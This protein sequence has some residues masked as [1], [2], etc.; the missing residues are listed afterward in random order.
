M[1]ERSKVECGRRIWDQGLLGCL[2]ELH[3]RY[4]ELEMYADD[5]LHFPKKSSE[6][7]NL[8]VPEAGVSQ[9]VEKSGW[10]KQDGV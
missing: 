8:E 9:A 10:V 2:H 5:G 3:R 4:P 7:P 1:R 6:V